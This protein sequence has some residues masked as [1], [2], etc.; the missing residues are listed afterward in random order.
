MFK[1][2]FLNRSIFSINVNYLNNSDIPDAWN[3]HFIAVMDID[4]K[5]I[6]HILQNE[7]TAIDCASASL[8]CGY[9]DQR[10]CTGQPEPDSLRYYKVR[11]TCFQ[12]NSCITLSH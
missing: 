5:I 11:S 7:K 9:T 2:S 1:Y 10:L 8:G 6:Y 12:Y 4:C 3:V